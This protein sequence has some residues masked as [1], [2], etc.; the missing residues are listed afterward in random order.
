MEMKTIV[1]KRTVAEDTERENGSE[2]CETPT[3][4][5]IR[6]E[7]ENGAESVAQGTLKPGSP[8]RPLVSEEEVRK[9]AERLYGIIVL[10]M[11]EL[12]SYD[13][14]NFMI[15][16]DRYVQ[17]TILNVHTEQ[18]TLHFELKR[19]VALGYGTNSNKNNNDYEQ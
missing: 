17:F 5:N 18:V 9:L 16:A 11:C 8:I 2:D 13:D 10:E 19:F 6:D 14:R 4:L 3:G 12:D 7:T 1:K 15:H